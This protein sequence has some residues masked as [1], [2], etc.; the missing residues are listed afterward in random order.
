METPLSLS[1]SPG[2]PS[3]EIVR[4]LLSPTDVSEPNVPNFQKIPSPVF[5]PDPAS[6]LPP[7]LESASFLGL[8]PWSPR[9]SQKSS[10]LFQ[11]PHLDQQCPLTYLGELPF[12]HLVEGDGV[13]P[14]ATWVGLQACF[15]DR[16]PDRSIPHSGVRWRGGQNVWVTVIWGQF[17]PDSLIPPPQS[18]WR[19]VEWTCDGLGMYLQTPS[20]PLQQPSP[21][22]WSPALAHPQAYPLLIMGCRCA[23]PTQKRFS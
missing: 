18:Q 23:G 16:K 22:V 1:S 8:T 15:A 2:S 19:P 11:H 9:M 12:L 4:S 7:A 13:K 10:Q 14:R 5:T 3:L 17:P 6:A 21:G 20:L